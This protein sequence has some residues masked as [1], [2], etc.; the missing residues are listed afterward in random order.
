MTGDR[1][2]QLLE[3]KLGPNPSLNL[4]NNADRRPRASLVSQLGPTT[5]TE[6]M[7]TFDRAGIEQVLRDYSGTQTPSEAISTMLHPQQ[8][9]ML[10]LLSV[11]ENN[12]SRAVP[13]SEAYSFS[14]GHSQFVPSSAPPSSNNHPPPPP[15]NDLQTSNLP[16]YLVQSQLAPFT[17][18]FSHPFQSTSNHSPHNV[19]L[20]PGA[21]ATPLSRGD[22]VDGSWA[23]ELLKG[24]KSA[25][26]RLQFPDRGTQV[27]HAVSLPHPVK[28]AHSQHTQATPSRS[29]PP[30]S[31]AQDAARRSTS[32]TSRRSPRQSR[33]NSQGSS[34][35]SAYEP[36][37]RKRRT[38]SSSRSVK[39]ESAATVEEDGEKKPVIACHMCRAR[40]LKCNG[41]RPKCANC[42]RRNEDSCEYDTVLRRRGPGRNNKKDR[43]SR[44]GGAVATGRARGRGQVD[45]SM[46]RLTPHGTE[47]GSDMTL[48]G[49]GNISAHRQ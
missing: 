6:D 47:E 10:S 3:A 30:T 21:P 5:E 24:Y 16:A 1:F 33:D 38:I 26:N 9:G 39:K 23:M 44:T 17:D 14:G 15:R 20:D 49:M 27:D 28:K 18:L 36:K 7:S 34:D 29:H 46:D 42:V 43:R 8:Y 48:L 11:D 31:P 13:S 2:S 40:K 35:E 12:M 45:S 32:Q 41:V 25:Q 37:G 22:A 4:Q 19:R